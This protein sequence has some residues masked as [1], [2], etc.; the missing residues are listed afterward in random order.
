M[1]GEVAALRRIARLAD[2]CL[3][4]EL[5]RGDGRPRGPR[6]REL[7]DAIEELRARFPY[8]LEAPGDAGGT[9][10]DAAQDGVGTLRALASLPPAELGAGTQLL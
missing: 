1:R 3:E 9:V 8:S 2:R 10:A 6:F 7:A 5:R 4:L